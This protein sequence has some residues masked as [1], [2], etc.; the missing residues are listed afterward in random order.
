MVYYFSLTGVSFVDDSAS[1]AYELVKTIVTSL[2]RLTSDCIRVIVN[3][4]IFTVAAHWT[5]VIADCYCLNLI[6]AII[7]YFETVATG[8][9]KGYVSDC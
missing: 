5:P 1:F 8:V 2:F 7:S 9:I 4:L 3:V 6:I